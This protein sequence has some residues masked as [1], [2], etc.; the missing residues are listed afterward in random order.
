[1]KKKFP[2][3]SSCLFD[4]SDPKFTS[5]LPLCKHCFEEI[6]KETRSLTQVTQKVYLGDKEVANNF[7]LLKKT[8]ITHILVC[9]KNLQTNFPEE[10]EYLKLSLQDSAFD[11][12]SRHLESSMNFIREAKKILI[13]CNHGVSRS[14]SIVIA[15]LMANQDLT[16]EEAFNLVKK[17][18]E[19]VK[20]NSGFI[21]QLKEFESRLKEMK[22][23][24]IAFIKT[25]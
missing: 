3:C 23:K 20:P 6:L 10:F 5:D 17:K 25:L 9:G 13:H 19:M 24:K 21:K 1:M 14:P 12:I 18:R 22:L 16:F 8:G 2:I 15:Y 4:E 7:E 11:D